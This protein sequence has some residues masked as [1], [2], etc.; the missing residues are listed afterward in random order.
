VNREYDP[1][2]RGGLFP[3]DGTHANQREVE[4]WYQMQAYIIERM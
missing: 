3:L 2:G 1:D 4:L